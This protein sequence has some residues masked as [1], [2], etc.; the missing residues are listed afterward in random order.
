MR[1]W[2]MRFWD[3]GRNLRWFASEKIVNRHD[4]SMT[5]TRRY[6]RVVCSTTGMSSAGRATTLLLDGDNTIR[7]TALDGGGRRRRT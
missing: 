7:V 6:V 3:I 5:Y 2:D 4:V 1:V